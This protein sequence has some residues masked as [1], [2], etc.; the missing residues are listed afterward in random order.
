MVLSLAT[1]GRQ[2]EVL[3][4]RWPEV[5]LK[6]GVLVFRDT[7]NGD[8]RAVPL[9]AAVLALL[10]ERRQVVRLDTDLLFPS[11]DNPVKPADLRAAFRAAVRR[12]GIAGFRWHDQR[13]SAA[14]ALADTGASLLD[15]GTVLG[16]RSQQTTKRYDHLTESRFRDLIQQ[17]ANKHKVS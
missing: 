3:G 12:A 2:G 14:S 13:H 11:R 17:A 15:I 10:R 7:K 6:Q 16:H 8:S 1:G 5:D 4:L 9:P